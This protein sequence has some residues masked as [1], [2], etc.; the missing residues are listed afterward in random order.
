MATQYVNAD[1]LIKKRNR[2]RSM[3]M[4][5]AS[6]KPI[7]SRVPEKAPQLVPQPHNKE[8]LSDP[9][10]FWIDTFWEEDDSASRTLF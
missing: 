7:D 2:V 4:A 1:Y 3:R 5:K 10:S 9:V 8:P 6:Q